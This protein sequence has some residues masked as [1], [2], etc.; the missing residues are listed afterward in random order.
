MDDAL[1]LRRRLAET[2]GWCEPR[3]ALG[4]AANSLR[5][6]DLLPAGLTYARTTHGYTMMEPELCFLP[7]PDARAA[8]DHVAATR[9]RLLQATNVAPA[10]LTLPLRPKSILAYAPCENL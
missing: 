8:V 5:T 10:Q 1:N 9:S 7:A 3:F 6:P 4:D 2:I